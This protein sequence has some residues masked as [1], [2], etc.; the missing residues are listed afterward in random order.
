MSVFSVIGKVFTTLFDVLTKIM[1]VMEALKALI[2]S[3]RDEIE[4][5]EGLIAEGEEEASEFVLGIETELEIIQTWARR[6]AL[7]G[8][9]INRTV[10]M[11]RT[12][13]ESDSRITTDEI[14]G[15]VASLEDAIGAVISTGE[16][17]D[18]ML[19]ALE[20]VKND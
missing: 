15:I 5:V 13:A 19:K 11:L 1:P 17:T 14:Q 16:M 8:S 18:D 6:L 3:L 12:A 4:Q 2:P 7:S 10:E 9:G 20:K